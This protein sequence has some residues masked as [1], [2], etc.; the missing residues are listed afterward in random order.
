MTFVQRSCQVICVISV[1]KNRSQ[2]KTQNL[3]FFTENV[4]KSS[5]KQGR[6][7]FIK[8]QIHWCLCFTHCQQERRE[9]IR[10]INSR[11][12][13]P[14]FCQSLITRVHW[15]CTERI[16][17]QQKW[18]NRKTELATARRHRTDS[19]LLFISVQATPT[20]M[21]QSK[22]SLMTITMNDSGWYM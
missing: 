17:D 11:P 16:D 4:I 2:K 9:I 1:L 7:K 14:I 12:K 21:S 6:H 8:L 13:L 15:I 3:S 10:K 19:L 20:I 22:Y 5:S 18:L